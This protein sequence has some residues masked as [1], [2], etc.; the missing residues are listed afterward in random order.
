MHSLRCATCQSELAQRRNSAKAN[1][2]SR[3]Q[4]GWP[5]PPCDSNFARA[6][7]ADAT[8]SAR[9]K[10]Q[11][12]PPQVEL[13]RRTTSTATDE[14]PSESQVAF[15]HLSAPVCCAC[16]LSRRATLI[17]PKVRA[18]PKRAY[19]LRDGT[20]ICPR[21]PY[22]TRRRWRRL[23]TWRGA[24]RTGPARAPPPAGSDA[25]EPLSDTIT[26]TATDTPPAISHSDAASEQQICCNCRRRPSL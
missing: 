18:E 16:H 20:H 7:L 8:Q 23:G 24:R 25:R 9:E 17:V 10:S 13:R 1:E 19:D 22:I 6:R 14:P 21:R 3:Q 2:L 12:P 11:P 26:Q 5:P 4:L 15:S